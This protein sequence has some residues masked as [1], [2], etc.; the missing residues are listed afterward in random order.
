MH[1]ARCKQRQTAI[2][3]HIFL[4]LPVHSLEVEEAKGATA[5]GVSVDECQ[6]W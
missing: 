4:A 1:P 6:M 3:L 2:R 5:E